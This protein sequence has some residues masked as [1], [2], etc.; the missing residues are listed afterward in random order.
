[1]V[2]YLLLDLFAGVAELADALDS[3]SSAF[4]GVGVRI[5]SP[6]PSKALLHK[7][8]FIFGESFCPRALGTFL[9]AI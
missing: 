6:A 4:T 7:A 1:M 2:Y 5:P 9:G 8:F 3:G